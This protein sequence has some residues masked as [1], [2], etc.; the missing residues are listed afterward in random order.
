MLSHRAASA[1]VCEVVQKAA[2]NDDGGCHRG[3]PLCGLLGKLAFFAD[4]GVVE[5]QGVLDFVGCA[6]GGG[7]CDYG[8][9]CVHDGD[10]DEKDGVSSVGETTP[11]FPLP[12]VRV[13]C[14]EYSPSGRERTVESGSDARAGYM[15][16]A[17]INAP[18]SKA[19]GRKD[20]KSFFKCFI[21]EILRFCGAVVETVLRLL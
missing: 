3:N 15:G 20:R 13:T 16:D 5:G 21:S 11:A 7:V 10:R 6:H 4:G 18:A 1:L 17:M 8:H 14:T 19:A 9:G 12:P 2:D